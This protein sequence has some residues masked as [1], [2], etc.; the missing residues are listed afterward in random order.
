MNYP[1]RAMAQLAC[2]DLQ[3]G[4]RV[5]EC[6]ALEMRHTGKRIGSSNLPLSAN[7]L[8]QIR[9]LAASASAVEMKREL[10]SLA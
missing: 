1:P 5:V 6:T 3:R 2:V 10:L 9:I 4:G 8:Y 7:F